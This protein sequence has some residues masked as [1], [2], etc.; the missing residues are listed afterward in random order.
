M[1]FLYQKKLISL[2]VRRRTKRGSTASLKICPFLTNMTKNV[3]S[4]P[5]Q[6]VI[7]VYFEIK[8]V[9]L[10]VLLTLLVSL[11]LII[12]Q[13]LAVQRYILTQPCLVR[14][15][16]TPPIPYFGPLLFNDLFYIIK[17]CC[18]NYKDTLDTF[19]KKVTIRYYAFRFRLKSQTQQSTHLMMHTLFS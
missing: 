11:T 16:N 12:L 19:P 17:C 14:L 3:A 4:F 5:Q 18:V 1:V 7:R 9:L 6:W 2:I 15:M 10:V 13:Q 8:T